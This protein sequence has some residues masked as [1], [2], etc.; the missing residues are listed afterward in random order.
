MSQAFGTAFAAILSGGLKSALIETTLLSPALGYGAIF[1]LE[2]IIMVVSIAVLRAVSVDA[3]RG[4][5]RTAIHK[6]M[7]LGAM[8]S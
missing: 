4:A 1:G 3:F 8:A 5:T 7:E 2:T 6:V